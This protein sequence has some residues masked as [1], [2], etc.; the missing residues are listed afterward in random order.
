VFTIPENDV[1]IAE[2]RIEIKAQIGGSF[3]IEYSRTGGEGLNPWRVAKT[4]D[5][6]ILNVSRI[7]KYRKLIRCRR[8]AWRLV[9]EQGLFDIM[10]YEIHV[11]QAGLSNK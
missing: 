7:I 9:A 8:F 11:Y 6:Q 4:I 5:P 2:I 1:Y 10:S 3:T